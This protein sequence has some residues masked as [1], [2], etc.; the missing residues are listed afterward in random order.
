VTVQPLRPSGDPVLRTPAAEVVDFDEQLR[1][2]LR[3]L[4]DTMEHRGG[5]GLAAPQIGVGLRA[6]TYHCDGFAGYLVNPTCEVVG[7]GRRTDREGCLSLPEL[8]RDCARHDHVVARGRNARGEPAEV[9]GT[10]RLARCLQ[11]ETDH[12]D[13]VL[14][15]DR[16]ADRLDGAREREQRPAVSP[17]NRQNPHHTLRRGR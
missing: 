2:L 17:E 8:S 11:H 13:G 9:E 5:A 16:L 6:F 12:L 10:A 14:L 1:A 4:W 7:D 3:D 15:V